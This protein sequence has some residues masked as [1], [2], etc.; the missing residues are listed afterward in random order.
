MPLIP[1]SEVG[2]QCGPSRQHRER[3]GLGHQQLVVTSHRRAQ[4]QVPEQHPDREDQHEDDRDRDVTDGQAPGG[5]GLHLAG[6]PV[7]FVA[8]LLITIRVTSVA[9]G[10]ERDAAALVLLGRGQILRDPP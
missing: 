6:A 5:G 3:L 10:A 1:S 4:V 8:V 9:V 7:V 2:R